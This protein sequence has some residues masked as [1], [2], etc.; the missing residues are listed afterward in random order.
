MEFAQ[1]VEKHWNFNSKPGKK[2]FKLVI[3]CFKIHF[4]R[5][6]LQEKNHLHLCHIYI[7]NI[8]TIIRSQIDLEFHCFYL[9]IS[10]KIHV[11]LCHQRSSNSG[12]DKDIHPSQI[13]SVCQVLLSD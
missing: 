13:G 4:L 12:S 7:I 8:Y 6:Y 11:I 5:C 3:C 10:W 2:P 1:K 9:E